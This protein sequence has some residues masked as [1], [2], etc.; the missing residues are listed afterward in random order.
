MRKGQSMVLKSARGN[1]SIKL[2]MTK[3]VSVD[4]FV[5]ALNE[6]KKVFNIGEFFLGQF[7]EQ[8]AEPP[9]ASALPNQGI[10]LLNNSQLRI[11]LDLCGSEG[12]WGVPIVLVGVA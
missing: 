10:E 8:Y 4:L 2:E 11:D 9:L 7:Y 1:Y 5:F 12:I 6:E 3:D